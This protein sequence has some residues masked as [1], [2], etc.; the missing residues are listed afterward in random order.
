MKNKF[1]LVLLFY[2]FLSKI[3]AQ[4]IP[5]KRPYKVSKPNNLVDPVWDGRIKGNYKISFKTRGLNKGD[6]VYLA[7]HYVGGKY[8][9]DTAVVDKSHCKVV[10]DGIEPLI[11]S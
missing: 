10:M 8:L 3:D 6:I 7:D 4:I 5:Y 11:I 2:F 9:R 1:L